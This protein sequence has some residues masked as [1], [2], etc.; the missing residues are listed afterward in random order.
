MVTDRPP[1]L[2]VTGFGLSGWRSCRTGGG[3]ASQC[4]TAERMAIAGTG[5]RT[6]YHYHMSGRRARRTACTT[7]TG[8]RGRSSSCRSRSDTE[9]RTYSSRL[10][11]SRSYSGRWAQ[12][13]PAPHRS[14]CSRFRE[15]RLFRR[16]TPRRE[17]RANRSV[18][19]WE[20]RPAPAAEH[21]AAA[22][23]MVV[24]PKQR[25]SRR[26]HRARPESVYALW[27]PFREKGRFLRGYSSIGGFRLVPCGNRTAEGERRAIGARSGAIKMRKSPQPEEGTRQ[28][29]AVVRNRGEGAMNPGAIISRLRSQS[30]TSSGPPIRTSTPSRSTL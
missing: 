21:T 29:V 25:R 27:I 4:R 12:H 19:Q 6:D 20:R 16:S 24:E 15:R 3:T 1:G 28:V 7:R 22:R 13:P 23:L 18:L 8:R 30:A 10:S 14:W 5:C 2:P 26:T 11:P 17:R 9:R